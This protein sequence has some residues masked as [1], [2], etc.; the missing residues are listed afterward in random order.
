QSH[1]LAGVVTIGPAQ[2]VFQAKRGINLK[3]STIL[4]STIG[5]LGINGSGT[6]SL[7][8]IN[9][10]GKGLNLGGR[11]ARGVHRADD[12]AHAGSGNPVDGNVILF[13]PFNDTDFGQTVS[14]TTT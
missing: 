7:L 14:T 13:H 12:A 11:H 5:N 10:L 9:F 3:V 8:P 4:L 1:T 6:K 2:S